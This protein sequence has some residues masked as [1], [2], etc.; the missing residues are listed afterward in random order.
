MIDLEEVGEVLEEDAVDEVL[1]Q[2]EDISAKLKN[3]L[4][5]SESGG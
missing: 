4:G 2:C 1:R 3:A 5:S